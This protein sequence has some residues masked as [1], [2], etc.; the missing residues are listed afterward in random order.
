MKPRSSILAA[1][2]AARASALE[3]PDEVG[4]L[5]AMGWN[6]WNEYGC[7][8]NEEIFLT[9]A[10]KLISTGLA[11]LGYVYVNVDDCWSD[12]NKGRD[13][14]TQQIIPDSS[15]FPT[16][17]SGLADQIHELGLKVGIYSDA[18]TGTCLNYPASL[19]HESIDASTFAEWGIDYLKYDNCYV[20]SEYNDQYSFDPENI[21][22][23]APADYDWSTSKSAARFSAMRDAL[24]EQNRTILYSICNWGQ[25]HVDLWGNNTGHSWRSSGDII[26]AWTGRFEFDNSWGITNIVNQAAFF[27]NATDFWGHGDWDMLEVGRGNLTLEENRSHFALWAAFKSPLILGTPLHNIQDSILE[28]IS[29]KELIGFNQDPVYGFPASPYKWGYREDFTYDPTYP[30]EFWSGSSVAGIHVFMLN[31]QGGTENKVADFAE[32]PALKELE[33]GASYLVHDMWT[34]EDLGEFTD[35]YSVDVK[36]HD[37]VA[38]R[39]TLPDG[40]HPNPT[41]S[42]R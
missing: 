23:N 16:G 29:N 2:L 10:E 22:T 32:I 40:S 33:A 14:N 21:Q 41:W 37:T 13:P 26:D 20:P 15:K 19:G 24:L 34:G 25:A 9:T 7:N 17:I 36:S 4:R 30:A 42:P 28:I 18:G 27:W 5:P 8:I 6:S 3:S 31:T 39:I 11:D 38:L 35:S 12:K 1:S